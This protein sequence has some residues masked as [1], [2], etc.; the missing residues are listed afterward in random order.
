MLLFFFL[1]LWS[2]TN[3]LATTLTV[4]GG[5]LS[6]S[7]VLA[8]C[9]LIPLGPKTPSLRLSSP[10]GPCLR[11]PKSNPC[12]RW[13]ASVHPP[14]SL[15][16][17]MSFAASSLLSPCPFFQPFVSPCPDSPGPVPGYMSIYTQDPTPMAQETAQPMVRR[18]RA[19]LR[20]S[21]SMSSASLA[22]ISSY[23][24]PPIWDLRDSLDEAYIIL[25][26]TLQ[27]SGT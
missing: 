12:P 4:P 26:L 23:P 16:F 24:S 22:W 15:G 25:V 17:I 21:N 2:P 13:R 14:S 3:I 20:L 9:L 27:A 19:F 5:L 18:P 1:F 7:P 11:F 10:H 6:D 8:L